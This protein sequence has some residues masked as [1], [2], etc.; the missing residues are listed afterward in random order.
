MESYDIF[1]DNNSA[2]NAEYGYGNSE[3]EMQKNYEIAKAVEAKYHENYG[4]IEGPRIGDIVEFS[5]GFRVYKH[6]KIVEDVYHNKEHGLLCVCKWFF[7][8]KWRIFLHF[9]RGIPQ[10]PQVI[11]STCWYRREHGLDM[12]MPRSRC[13]PRNLL[14]LE[15]E[16]MAHPIRANQ[17]PFNSHDKKERSWQ[18]RC[19]DPK[20]RG[21]VQSNQV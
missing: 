21:L 3:S 10:F 18:I 9:R 20:F 16:K 15:G 1:K 5:D 11:V 4:N 2:W 17:S 13:A 6:A 12:G 8:Y 14:H 7:P 19:R